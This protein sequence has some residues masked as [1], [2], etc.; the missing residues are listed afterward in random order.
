MQFLKNILNEPNISK[1]KQPQQFSCRRW[2]EFS[3]H[4]GPSLLRRPGISWLSAVFPS[5]NLLCRSPANSYLSKPQLKFSQGFCL[6][7]I[8]QTLAVLSLHTTAPEKLPMVTARSNTP[9]SSA[10]CFTLYNYS[11]ST[12]LQ[13]ALTDFSLC[14]WYLSMPHLTGAAATRHLPFQEGCQCTPSWD[15]YRLL[16]PL[17]EWGPVSTFK[18]K[19]ST[20]AH[21]Q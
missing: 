5:V 2:N 20:F 14:L 18:I 1:S 7:L 12:I 19:F 15:C 17:T 11:S 8:L 3:P 10:L 4:S 6:L 16:S 21:V 13:S 9:V